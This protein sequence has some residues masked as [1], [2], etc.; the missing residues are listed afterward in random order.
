MEKEGSVLIR[1]SFKKSF[2]IPQTC[3]R[4]K[5]MRLAKRHVSWQSPQFISLDLRL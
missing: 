3:F 1:T 2:P 4:H 5:G